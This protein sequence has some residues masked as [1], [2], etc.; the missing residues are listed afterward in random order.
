MFNKKTIIMNIP[1][2]CEDDS[3]SIRC[4]EVFQSIWMWYKKIMMMVSL[5]RCED[6]D[7][8]VCQR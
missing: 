3:Q 1:V 7:E 5:E 8:F 4:E 6:G 2:R